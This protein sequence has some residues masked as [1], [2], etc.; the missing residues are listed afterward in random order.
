MDI[1]T[2]KL[3]LLK[4]IIETENTEL[5]Q[6]IADFVKTEKKDFWSSLSKDQK[7]EINIGI[8]QLD[9]GKRISYDVVLNKIS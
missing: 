5:I 9:S 7:E 8:Q 6:K 1:Q 2:I 4:T 3:D